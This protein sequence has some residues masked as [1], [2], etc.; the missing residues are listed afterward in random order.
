MCASNIETSEQHRELR[1]VEHD[2][3]CALAKTRHP[4][5]AACE[6]FVIQ[7]E[8]ASVPEQD[9]DPVAAAAD[10]HEQVSCEWIE[11][12]DVSYERAEPI[13]TA[14]KIDRLGREEDLHPGGERQHVARTAARSAATYCS[15]LPTGT[16]KVMRS[17]TSIVIEYGAETAGCPA[18]STTGSSVG[19]A[20]GEL[21][22]FRASSQ[23]HHFKCF[24][25][26]P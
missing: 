1:R 11:R 10:E 25:V 22:A 7:D 9:L 3:V 26:T 5:P 24:A 4:E 21:V 14:A 18:L 12:E 8:S 16:R 20:A 2:V 23:R 6:P 15:S 19:A 13:V 17:S